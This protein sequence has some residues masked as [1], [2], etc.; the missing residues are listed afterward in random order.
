M[1]KGGGFTPFTCSCCGYSPSETLWRRHLAEWHSLSD[2]DR[3]ARRAEHRDAGDDMNSHKQHYHQ[4]L[5]MPPLPHHGMERCGVDDL[6]LLYLNFFKHLFKYTV[7]EALP[8]SKKKLVAQ[9]LK[10]AGFYSYDAASVDDDPVSHWIGREVKRFMEEAHL[11]LPFLLRL[12]ASPADCIPEMAEMANDDGDQEMELDDEYAPTEAD[13]AQEEK[14]EPLMMA[15]TTRWDNFFALVH[16][17]HRPRGADDTDEYRKARAVEVFQPG[18]GVRQRP[19]RAQA[20]D[21]DVGA[22]HPRLRRAAPDGLSR[23]PDAAVVRRV[24]VL[25]RDGEEAH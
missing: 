2:E 18:L 23:R 3:A 20:D 7:H 24:R 15:N 12:A 19:A 8:D 25:R 14:E 17:L 6:H 11:H 16:S 9:Y 4:E 10:G 21:A 1:A 22:A 13:I 5:F